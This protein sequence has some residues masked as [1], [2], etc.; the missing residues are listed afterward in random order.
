MSQHTAVR[1]KGSRWQAIANRA[2]REHQ[3]SSYSTVQGH[4][5]GNPVVAGNGSDGDLVLD[6]AIRHF[7][8]LGLTSREARDLAEALIEAAETGKTVTAFPASSS[9]HPYQFSR[10]LAAVTIRHGREVIRLPLRA[11]RRL[12]GL[13]GRMVKTSTTQGVAA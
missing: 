6:L 1:I 12:A 10:R 5:P 7:S 8:N 2:P 4:R 3:L 11:A 9:E 13:L